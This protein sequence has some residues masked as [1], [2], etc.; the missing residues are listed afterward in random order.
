MANKGDDTRDDGS[1]ASLTIQI[2][3][4]TLACLT[5]CE[6][7]LGRVAQFT[8]AG[9][10]PDVEWLADSRMLAALT[11]QAVRTVEAKIR[12]AGVPKHNGA[13]YSMR[14]YRECARKDD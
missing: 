11:N 1:D 4:A 10:L 8:D 2:Q 12:D 14:D 7:I 9:V 13:F 6:K 3:Q 5:H